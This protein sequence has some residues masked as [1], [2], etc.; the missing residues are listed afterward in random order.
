MMHKSSTYRLYYFYNLCIK[1]SYS[2]PRIYI[3]KF[4]SLL[5][6]YLLK[7]SAKSALRATIF[8]LR[9]HFVLRT[10]HQLPTLMQ[11]ETLYTMTVIAVLASRLATLAQLTP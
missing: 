11:L 7:K 4:Y 6:K 2:S 1:L 3:I 8:M 10:A 9:T 5:L